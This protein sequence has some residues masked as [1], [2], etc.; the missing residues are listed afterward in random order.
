MPFHDDIDVC[1]MEDTMDRVI[2]LVNGDASSSLMLWKLEFTSSIWRLRYRDPVKHLALNNIN[3][4]VFRM[5]KE[6]SDAAFPTR[7]R[8]ERLATRGLR[9]R[10]AL[11]LERLAT[12]THAHNAHTH[13]HVCCPTH[14]TVV[15]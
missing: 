13:T 5:R 9:F 2:Q 8:L 1:M 15:N 14:T 12:P 6:A 11:V 7:A 3:I 4:D 10:R